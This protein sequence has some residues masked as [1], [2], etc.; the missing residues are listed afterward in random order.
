MPWSHADGTL[1]GK[2]PFDAGHL[3]FKASEDLTDCNLIGSLRE[4]MPA[5]GPAGAGYQTGIPK[6][7]QDLL[8]IVVRASSDSGVA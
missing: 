7:T 2:D 1:H 5:R 8:Q 6:F 4:D 3:P